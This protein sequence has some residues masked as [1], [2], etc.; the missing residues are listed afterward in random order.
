MAERR[1]AEI[2]RQRCGLDQV[3][4]NGVLAEV[5][6]LLV[7]ACRYRLGDLRNFEGVGQAITEKVRFR[8]REELGLALQAP[9]SRAAQKASI[10]PTE[11]TSVRARWLECDLSLRIAGA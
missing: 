11:V 4:V 9:K 1:V 5:T 7:D 6:M 2:V 8:A 10:V 3:E